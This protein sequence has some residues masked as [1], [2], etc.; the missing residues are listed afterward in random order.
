MGIGSITFSLPHFLSDNYMV[1]SDLNSTNDNIC[2]VPRL[3][4]SKSVDLIP[5]LDKIQSLTEGKNVII[6]EKAFPQ[7]AY[8]IIHL[9]VTV[10]MQWDIV[11]QTTRGSETFNS[12]PR[13]IPGPS[14]NQFGVVYLTRPA[15]PLLLPWLCAR[16]RIGSIEASSDQRN[17]TDLQISFQILY[18]SITGGKIG[19]PVWTPLPLA[20]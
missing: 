4:Q 12:S 17:L 6:N 8:V 14:G 3:S 11:K 9:P 10:S 1:H 7:N 15:A 19:V 18:T 2:R 13:T 5:G 16:T 20:E